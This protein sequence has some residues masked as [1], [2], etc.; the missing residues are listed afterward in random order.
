V[1]PAEAIV[2]GDINDPRSRVSKMARMD[3]GYKMFT[4]LGVKPSVTYL[5][6]I[7]NPVLK[8][9]HGMNSEAVSLPENR[10]P[11]VLR[12]PPVLAGEFGDSLACRRR[13]RYSLWRLTALLI[14]LGNDWVYS[15]K[16]EARSG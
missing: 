3:R 5:V 2:F 1:C 10:L 9:R 11:E 15:R 7:S 8:K 14:S 16:S 12:T 13:D 6:D 4:E